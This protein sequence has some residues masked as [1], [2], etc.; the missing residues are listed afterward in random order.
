MK[1]QDKFLDFVYCFLGSGMLINSYNE[2]VAEANAKECE[3]I[4][5]DFA[6]GFAEWYDRISEE[7]WGCH[8]TQQLLEIYKKEK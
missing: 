6:V 7:M 3:K 1:L 2:M 4:A 5:D 8:T